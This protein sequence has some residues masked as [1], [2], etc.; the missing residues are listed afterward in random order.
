MSVTLSIAETEYR[1]GGL[2][3]PLNLDEALPARGPW[4]VEIGFGKGRYLLKRA[5]ESPDVRFLGVEMANAYYRLALRRA[6]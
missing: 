5:S 4:E 3:I 6:R 2:P 1:L